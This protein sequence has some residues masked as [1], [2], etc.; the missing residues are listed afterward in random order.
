MRAM[1]SLQASRAL[2]GTLP[3]ILVVA[4]LLAAYCF[5][6]LWAEPYVPWWVVTLVG[7]ILLAGLQFL[8]SRWLEGDILRAAQHDPE[9]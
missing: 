3:R 7:L 9:E 4:A 5:A 6:A 2:F 1:L 8:G